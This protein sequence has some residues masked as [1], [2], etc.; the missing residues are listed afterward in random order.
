[1]AKSGTNTMSKLGIALA[2]TFL[3]LAW[4]FILTVQDPREARYQ[5]E[6]NVCIE[7]ANKAGLDPNDDKVE[8]IKTCME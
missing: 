1:M 3:T 4:Y 5:E 8:F 2:I 7:L 6:L